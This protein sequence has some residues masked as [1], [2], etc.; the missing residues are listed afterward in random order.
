MQNCT[1][2]N[3]RGVQ[4]QQPIAGS[5]VLITRNRHHNIQGVA[6]TADGPVGNF[7][8]FRG[9]QNASIEV[10]WNEIDNEYNLSNPT[11]II[12]IFGSAHVRLHDNMLWHQSKPGNAYNTSTQNGITIEG[13]SFDNEVWNNQVI[14]GYGIGIF[15]GHDNYV[16]DNR[17]VQDGKLPD[18]TRIGNGYR[19]LRI[20]PG[21][22]NNYAHRNIVGYVNRDGR[23][24]DGLS[25]DASTGDA[26]KGVKNTPLRNP[27]TQATERREWK[28]WQK[29]LAATRILLGA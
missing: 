5:T 21:G 20:L 29:K 27:I 28:L 3:T 6:N 16:H 10:S 17:I 4:L 11:D 25:V 12:S 15:A 22:T 14:D 2:E 13:D 1:I 24:S 7:V 9:V 23:R 8:Q 19:A 18:G 26:G